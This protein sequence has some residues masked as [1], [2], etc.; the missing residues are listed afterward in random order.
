MAVMQNSDKIIVINT[1][2]NLASMDRYHSFQVQSS[3]IR[4]LT[5]I[6]W[7]LICGSEG[8]KGQ[9]FA[10]TEKNTCMSVDLPTK[11]LVWAFS[12]S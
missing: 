9:G 5:C 4:S 11:I 2:T 3:A 8:Q 6:L 7:K 12:T 1:G 10:F